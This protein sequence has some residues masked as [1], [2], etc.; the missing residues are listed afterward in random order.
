MSMTTGIEGNLTVSDAGDL[1]D[2]IA[3]I[4]PYSAT[5][6]VAVDNADVTAF[7]STPPVAASTAIGISAWTITLAARFP[8][9][10]AFGKCGNVTYANGYVVGPKAWSMAIACAV[11]ESTAFAS[12][13]PTYASFVP[14]MIS[15]TGSYTCYIDS[16][17]SL[18]AAATSGNATFRLT[19]E[20][21]VDNTLA[22]AIN[23][24]QKSAVVNVGAGNDVTYNFAAN[25]NITAAGD[26]TLFPAGALAKPDTAEVVLRAAGSKTYTGDAFWSAVNISVPVRGLIDVGMTLQGTG[27]LTIA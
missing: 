26:S 15:A 25:G 14:G 11:H 1:Q 4:K 18:A 16:A 9:T 5:L 20:T 7:S 8:T 12:T 21:T 10:A 22:C 23:S 6:N 27:D 17:T 2:I 24:I 13:C 3:A 19:D